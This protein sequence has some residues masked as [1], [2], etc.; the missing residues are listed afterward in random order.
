MPNSTNSFPVM[1]N[2][3]FHLSSDSSSLFSRSIETN[4]LFL[5]YQQYDMIDQ[6]SDKKL[7]FNQT[8]SSQP[9][10]KTKHT[11][12]IYIYAILFIIASIGNSTSFVALLFMN[13][14]TNKNF[15]NS[16]SRIRLLLMNLCIADLMVT[17][18]HLPL[19]IIWAYTDSWQAG[20]IMCKLMMFLRT[21]GHY[22]SSFVIITISI[23]IK[24]NLL[25]KKHSI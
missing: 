18:I 3:Y 22:L 16:R 13:K 10:S 15:K 21:F 11:E 23:G 9:L 8:Q 6:L 17:Y 12:K 24:I 1:F 20:E 4:D 5:K 19:E 7:H 2:Q 14:S 25:K